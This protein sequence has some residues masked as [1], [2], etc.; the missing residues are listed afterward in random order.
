MFKRTDPDD[1]EAAVIVYDEGR[2]TVSTFLSRE[3]STFASIHA[4][5]DIPTKSWC[6]FTIA[7]SQNSTPTSS[8]VFKPLLSE[9]QTIWYGGPNG[10]IS[11]QPIEG[12]YPSDGMQITSANSWAVTEVVTTF[13]S[14]V[15]I[16]P[17]NEDPSQRLLLRDIRVLLQE[18]NEV[19]N[20]GDTTGGFPTTSQVLSGSAY[21]AKPTFSATYRSLAS[22]VSGDIAKIEV[23]DLSSIQEQ[24]VSDATT[25]VSNGILSTQDDT[26]GASVSLDNVPGTSDNF[27]DGG[28]YNTTYTATQRLYGIGAYEPQGTYLQQT[29]EGIP[30]L[31]GPGSWVLYYDAATGKWRASYD[32]VVL[33]E[34]VVDTQLPTTISD[35]DLPAGTLTSSLTTTGGAGSNAVDP[36][37]TA[38]LTAGRNNAIRTRLRSPDFFFQ[39]SAVGRSW[40]LEDISADV[41]PGGPFRKV[42]S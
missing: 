22:S 24:D 21:P 19:L 20:V 14:R 29:D 28:A 12:A 11:V 15:L 4:L 27:I 42:N 25:V 6:P 31:Y 38:N 13:D 39:I 10:R 40:A 34:S 35:I 17:I 2:Q 5:Y 30:V 36:L 7:D 1:L 23:F 32:A 3:D 18:N 41:V 26:S 16:G 8:A 9:R 37:L 33:F